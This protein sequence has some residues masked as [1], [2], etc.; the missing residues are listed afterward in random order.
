V[1]LSANRTVWLH[2]NSQAAADHLA[3]HNTIA[4]KV[5]T[6]DVALSAPTTFDQSAY[7]TALTTMPGSITAPSMVLL[8]EVIT[9]VQ[10]LYTAANENRRMINAIVD[11][12]QS[13][14]LMA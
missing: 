3:D 14:G 2:A 8:S 11:A 12:L 10:A 13:A 5:N 1:P 7:S 9:S 6:L 4:A